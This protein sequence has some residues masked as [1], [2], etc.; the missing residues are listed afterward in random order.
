MAFDSLPVKPPLDPMLSHLEPEVPAG[1]GWRYE[2]KWDGF[3]AIVFRDGDQV[4][5]QSRDRRPLERFFPELPPLL[6]DAL[7]ERCVVDGEVVVQ[8]PHGLDFELLQMRL[9]PATSRVNK[10]AAETPSSFI[11]FDLIALGDQDLTAV[12]F[13]ERRVKLEGAIRVTDRVQVTPQTTD[14]AK[15]AEWLVGLESQ[16]FDG[17]VAK[18]D[19]LLYVPGQR[20]MVKLKRRRTA[21]VV[22][23]G[24]RLNK[25]KDGIGS[26]LLGM[27]DSKGTLQHIGHTSSFKA[28]ERR[29][30]LA[31]LKPLEGGTSFGEGRAPGG[32]SRWSRGKDMSWTAV[33]PTLV[34]EVSYDHLQRE[35]WREA[36]GD[37]SNYRF[38][39]A[40]RF[41]RWREDKPPKDC[42]TE[43]LLEPGR[44][45]VSASSK[46]ET[47]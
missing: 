43:Q 8:T 1:A 9:H 13:G 11:C 32:P 34:A 30:L 22:V 7:P 23:G 47:E 36:V 26:L 16:G 35:N 3:R 17:V 14:A 29:D 21:D 12:P 41:E 46:G 5:V 18:K 25:T 27:Y 19:D 10:L 45:E 44:L 28:K 33:T 37:G 31:R 15:A 6:K 40:S 4:H 42:R 24:Y 38:R 2:P 39:H 20:V